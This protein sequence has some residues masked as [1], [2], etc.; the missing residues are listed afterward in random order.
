LLYCQAKSNVVKPSYLAVFAVKSELIP[1]KPK[2]L[3]PAMNDLIRDYLKALLFLLVVMWFWVGSVAEAK[4]ASPNNAVLNISKTALQ[5]KIDALN[6]REGL[7]KILKSKM[8]SIYQNAQDNLLSIEILKAKAVAY[9][10]AIKQAPEK[11]K[12]L[13]K[14]IAQNEEKL[15]RQKAEDFGAITSEE[16]EQRLII[17]KGK[18]SNFDAQ[19][20]KLENELILQN[21]RLQQIRQESVSAQQDLDNNEKNLQAPVSNADSKLEVEAREVYLKTEIDAKSA[22]LKTLEYEAI[23]HPAR[24]ELLKSEIKLLGL[25]KSL[26]APVIASIETL[27]T[28]RRER[29]AK[30]MEDAFSQTEKE[31][32]GKH[33]VI[34]KLTRENI[35]YS[36]DLQAIAGKIDNY[37]E[38]K[39]K[40][41]A[42]ASEQDNDFKSAEKKISLAGLSPALGKILREQRRNLADWGQYSLQSET[43]QNETALTS[44]EQ[45]KIEDKQKKLAD[46]DTELR[47]IMG[48]E[49][50]AGLPKEQRMMIQAELRI[51]LDGQKEL[52]NKLAH[53]NANYL[54]A[55]GD[56][57]FAKQKMLAQ[58]E[59]FAVY[60]DKRLLWVPSSEPINSNYPVGLYHSARWLLSPRNWTGLL[61]DSLATVLKIPFLSFMALLAIAIVQLMSKWARQKLSEVAISVNNFNN[62]QFYF[63]LYA[64]VYTFILV[65]PMPMTIYSIGR[66]LNSNV[67][68][69][70]FS[71]A[72]ATG[73]Q[74]AAIPLLFLMYFYRLFANEGIACQHFNWSRESA[75]LVRKHLAWFRLI[76]I[77]CVF[78]IACTSASKIA[79]HSDNLGRLALIVNL[80][81]LALLF[82]YF[83]NPAKGLLRETLRI[84]S[85][86]WLAK[87]RYIWF[88]AF[89][90][91]LLVIMGFAFAGYYLSALELQQKLNVSFRLVFAAIFVHELVFRWLSLVNRQL[92]IENAKQKY[93]VHCQQEK[94]VAGTEDSILPLDEHQIDIPKINAQTIRLLNVFIGFSLI[95]GLGMIWKNILPAFSFLDQ[96]VLWQ[97]LVVTENEKVMQSIT[98][99]NLLLT[100][101]YVFIVVVAVRNFSGVMELL[102]FRRLDIEAGSRYAVNQL[103]KY[104]L[105]SIGFIAVANELGGS[106]AQVQWLVAALGV[107]LGFGLQEIFANLVSGIIILFERP[108][109]IGDTVTIGEVTGKVSRIQ[110]RATTLTDWDQK[111]LI[112]PNKTFIT[113]QLVNWTLSSAVTRITIPVGVAYGSKPEFVH[114]IIINTVQSTPLVLADPAPSVLCLG[115]GDS[116]I[117]FTIYVFV[118]E[119]ADRL[120]VTHD[121][122]MRIENAFRQHDIS[123]PFPQRDVHVHYVRDE[124]TALTAAFLPL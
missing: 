94:H 83:L 20:N 80:C 63:T 26:L 41:D 31:L 74:G 119:L 103:A 71:E 56:Y 72:I 24:L 75:A 42:L 73:L 7:D 106:W 9:E 120:P 25:Q 55:L 30:N 81:A 117:N 92:A 65:L 18:I 60:L 48:S 86:S 110:M 58:A 33:P 32:S 113:N 22:E 52:L 37:N 67:Q 54:R 101:L 88:S 99:T 49:V 34:Q 3:S 29:E 79:I 85:E 57:D 112:V 102:L 59:Q 122:H 97:H 66:L 107:G 105:V 93:R 38:Q 98:L 45:F 95:L 108:I 12:A 40:I 46:I 61:K 78:L 13:Q 76:A 15:A 5:A 53:S 43:L 36:R 44:L 8:L 1:I 17:E 10:Q 64:L 84:H 89:I 121:L 100:G 69:E 123:I 50:D 16:L 28:E 124:D 2:S 111:E 4:N 47:D 14:D 21:G 23:S 116:S 68:I 62:D 19:I 11:T 77:P 87:L 90:A 109:R 96:I 104:T 91:I 51:L 70:D 118:S 35:R 6:A 39:N 115:F 27:M 114:K 82:I